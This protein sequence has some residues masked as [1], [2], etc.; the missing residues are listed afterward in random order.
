MGIPFIF[1]LIYVYIGIIID[2]GSPLQLP[3][4]ELEGAY[5]FYFYR[6]NTSATALKTIFPST[7]FKPRAIGQGTGQYSGQL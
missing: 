5:G 1:A 7:M 2:K 4:G 3:K 6:P